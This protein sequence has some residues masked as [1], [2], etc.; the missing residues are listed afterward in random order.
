MIRS[1][2]FFKVSPGDT[3][4]AL[5][6]SMFFCFV[7]FFILV[8]KFHNY[9]VFKKQDIYNIEADEPEVLWETVGHI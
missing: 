5:F 7:F 2:Y 6:A 4:E 9:G 1:A 8:Q 3:V